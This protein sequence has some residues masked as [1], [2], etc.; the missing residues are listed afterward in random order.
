MGCFQRV[1][2]N[3]SNQHSDCGSKDLKS[4]GSKLQACVTLSYMLS[5][6][7]FN[8]RGLALQ[9][10]H[11]NRH[12]S[13]FHNVCLVTLY[14]PMHQSYQALVPFFY[15]DSPFESKAVRPQNPSLALNPKTSTQPKPHI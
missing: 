2:T 13:N 1:E 11:T 3:L 10:G 6:Q 5:G 8:P 14:Q 15:Q 9:N 12:S 4:S 7:L